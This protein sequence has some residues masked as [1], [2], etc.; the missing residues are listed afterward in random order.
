[1]SIKHFLF[2]TYVDKTF[3]IFDQLETLRISINAEEFY[4]I[5]IPTNVLFNT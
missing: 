2:L 3:S 1:M 5:W 4:E